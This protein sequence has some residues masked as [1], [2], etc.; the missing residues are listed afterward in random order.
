MRFWTT[1]ILLALVAA[2]AALWLY[3]DTI[4]PTV[5]WKKPSSEQAASARELARITPESLI[6]I[7]LD[8]VRLERQGNNWNLPGDWPTRSAE[9]SDLVNVLTS[10]QSRFAPEPFNHP[11]TFGLAADQKPVTIRVTVKSPEHGEK[12]Y[13]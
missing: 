10:L 1:L 11:Q 9:V 3:W 8:N 6:R 5:G 4:A 13:T 2:G 12:T 7:E